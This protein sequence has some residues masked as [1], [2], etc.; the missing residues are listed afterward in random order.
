MFS[1]A[2]VPT[3]AAAVLSWHYVEEPML[4]VKRFVGGSSADVADPVASNESVV[5]AVGGVG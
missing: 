4:R 1:I 5:T 2:L 3:A